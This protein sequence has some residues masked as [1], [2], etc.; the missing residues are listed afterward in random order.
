MDVLGHLNHS[1]DLLTCVL[2]RCHTPC[3]N[4]FIFYLNEKCKPFCFRF[5]VVF[6]QN[7]K[8]TH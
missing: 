1:G 4:Y 2:V 5:K 3:L 8:K 7:G 6:T